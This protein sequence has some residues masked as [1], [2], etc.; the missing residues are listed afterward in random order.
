MTGFQ[1]VVP[2]Q[3]LAGWR[4]LERTVATQKAAFENSAEFRRDIAY[5]EE[6]IRSA[7]T[8]DKLVDDRRLL[9][10]ALGAFGL[11][12]DLDKRAYIVKA[13]SEG[14]EDD[15]AFANRMVD[16]RYHDFSTAFGYGN[17]SG[18]RVD[19]PGFAQSILGAYKLH[20]FEV[21]VGESNESMRLAMT[22]VREIGEYANSTGADNSAWFSVIG[23]PPVSKVFQMAFGL[24]QSFGSLDVDKQREI[25]KE[26]NEKL[27]GD[28]S[29]AVFSDNT[30]VEKM[31]RQFFLR[32]QISNGTGGGTP[33][34][35]ALTLLRDSA[36]GMAQF[37]QL[38]I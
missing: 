10:V 21:A 17:R 14:T 25:L 31:L 3:G 38:R 15:T 24:P 33:G 37:F 27:F 22:F 19:T 18:A 13:L 20:R 36:N 29:I 4:F 32:E 16:K 2:Q 8:V 26:K 5:F 28:T 30:K 12:E 9:K 6:N 7:A 11:D 23:N 1:P 35:T 34:S